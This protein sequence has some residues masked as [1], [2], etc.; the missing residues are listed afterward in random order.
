MNPIRWVLIAALLAYR[1]ILSPA[2]NLLLGAAGCCRFTPSCSEFALEAVRR[3]GVRCGGAMAA[4]RLCRCHPWGGAGPD[5][6]PELG[7]IPS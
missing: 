6:V 1:W 4:R 2:K 7:K 5:P 3:H